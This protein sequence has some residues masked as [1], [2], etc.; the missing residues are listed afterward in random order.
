MELAEAN[1]KYNGLCLNMAVAEDTSR[2]YGG[3]KKV[4]TE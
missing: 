1:G 4:C 2:K 3:Y